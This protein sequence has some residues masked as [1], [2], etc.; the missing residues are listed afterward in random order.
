MVVKERLDTLLVQ[1]GLFP[2]RNQ[3]QAAIMAG[4]VEVA[5]KVVDKP[6]SRIARDARIGL[7]EAGPSFVSR[8]GLK[9]QRALVEFGVEVKGKVFIDVG[10]STGGFTEHLLKQ[11]ARR[12][13]AVDVGYGQ[14][15]W[16]LRQDPR[17]EVLER[18]NIRYLDSE[19]LVETPDAATVDVSFISLLKVIPNLLNLLKL[20]KEIIALVKPQFEIGKGKVEKGGLVRKKESHQEV[21]LSVWHKVEELGLRVRGITYSPVKGDKGNME[22]FLYLTSKGRRVG[23][24]RVEEKVRRIVDEAHEVLG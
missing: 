2:T 6:G 14:L 4:L 15:A 5:G 10:A 16:S 20:E 3:A 23:A 13:I 19:Q 9:L 22:F 8:G 18:R 12:V 11:G 1:R 7:K 24:K 21:L 17:V